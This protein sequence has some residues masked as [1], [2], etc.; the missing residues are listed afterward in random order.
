MN[1]KDL[2]KKLRRKIRKGYT[3]VS[4]T[5]SS[6]DSEQDGEGVTTRSSV[7]AVQKPPQVPVRSPSIE[8]ESNSDSDSN[9]GINVIHNFFFKKRE[10][11]L[12]KVFAKKNCSI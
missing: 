10:F 1:D 3:G 8:R 9:Q 12:E 5:S 11:N 4:E 2:A 7:K 6:S